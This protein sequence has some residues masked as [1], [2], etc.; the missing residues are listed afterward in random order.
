VVLDGCFTKVDDGV[1]FHEATHRS[2]DDAGTLAP[3]LQ[4][5]ILRLFQRRGLLDDHAVADI[6]T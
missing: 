3:I 6:L 4:R 1:C 2:A 5:R